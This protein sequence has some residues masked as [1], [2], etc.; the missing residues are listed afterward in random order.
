M[1]VVAF[2]PALS[3]TSQDAGGV[4]IEG[5]PMTS[6]YV[7]GFPNQI[8]VPVVVSV[9]TLGGSDY[10]PTRY[11]V[12]T[13]PEGERVGALEFSWS[14]PDNPPVPVKFRVFAQHLPM[15]VT[16]PGIYTLGLYENLDDSESDHLFPLPVF[17]RNPLWQ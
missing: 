9:A 1:R 12:A 6:C 10:E 11:I 13:S 5:F 15:R 14:W 16:N 8:T 3:A 7:D 2:A 4:A 17:K